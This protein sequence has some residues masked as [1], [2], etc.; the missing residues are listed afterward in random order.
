MKR[1]IF[2]LLSVIAC[3]SVTSAHANWQYAGKY[4]RDGYYTDNGGH[5]SIAIRGG[6][7][8]AHGKIKNKVGDLVTSYY[9]RSDG[10]DIIS[11]GY[12]ETCKDGSCKDFVL[13]GVGN[14]GDLPAHDDLD[15]F[16]FAAGASLGWTI[17]GSPQWRLEL[18]WDHMAKSD[19]DATPLFSGDL[20]LS[21]GVFGDAIASVASGSVHSTITTDVFSV[22]AFYDFFDGMYRPAR[23][24]IPYVGFGIGYADTKTVMQLTDLYGDLSV[25]ADLQHYAESD[26]FPLDFYKSDINTANIAGLLA[27]GVSYGLT[28][29]LF[30]D[31]GARLTYIPSVKWK[32]SSADGERT[33]DW[34]NA[35]SL[36]YATFTLGLRYEF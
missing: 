3:M 34:F 5:F 18:G 25:D 23:T 20:A 33:R 7:A 26:T 10:T 17:P 14:I 30:L 29:A 36:F 4:T 9:S 11:G 12:Y 19:Y 21:G 2:Y 27:A 6:A 28:N 13:A 24:L 1:N 16:S 32:L 31:F 8:I 15:T 22:M 35:D